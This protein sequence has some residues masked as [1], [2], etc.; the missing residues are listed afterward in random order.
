MNR[1]K[2]KLNNRKGASITWALLIFLVCAVV[3]SAV[4]VAGTAAAG[5]MSKLAENDQRYYAVTSAA[6]L[7]RD[8]L[9]PTFTV[10][11]SVTK[12]E[13]GSAKY[14]IKY[15]PDGSDATTDKLQKAL[16][17]KLME[18]PETGT[19]DEAVF[20]KDSIA[21]NSLTE[22]DDITLT[23]TPSDV[24]NALANV[25][26]RLTIGT[27]G[28]ILAVIK[29][30]SSDMPDGKSEFEIQMLFEMNRTITDID[31]VKTDTFS[32]TLLDARTVLSKD[33]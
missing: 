1:I 6:G 19:T 7:L 20:K 4:L 3:G 17:Q 13:D 31:G 25:N 2:N 30:N 16:V 28:S 27:D 18:W 24:S 5:R 29:K 23:S 15:N 9:S 21:A 14:E 10:K 12:A 26:C 33:K 8:A 22:I 11:R 32:W